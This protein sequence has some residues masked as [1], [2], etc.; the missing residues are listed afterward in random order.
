M[1]QDGDR[2]PDIH[3]VSPHNIY[4]FMKHCWDKEPSNRPTFEDSLNILS[5]F[6]NTVE[7]VDMRSVTEPS[8]DTG[9]LNMNQKRASYW[10]AY[11]ILHGQPLMA[12]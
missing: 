3:L 6:S 11:K 5:V 12:K 10:S 1:L 8:L 7:L 9:Y 2:L 4:L